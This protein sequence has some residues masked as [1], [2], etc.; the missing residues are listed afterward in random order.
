MY[1]DFVSRPLGPIGWEAALAGPQGHGGRLLP[2]L[3]H[4][5]PTARRK[6]WQEQCSKTR[7]EESLPSS[8][9][10]QPSLPVFQSLI[11]TGSTLGCLRST[12]R[13]VS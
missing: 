11:K 12:F 1:S 2:F 6:A 5:G 13:R 10:A 7:L 3:A 8:P 9:Q 4:L